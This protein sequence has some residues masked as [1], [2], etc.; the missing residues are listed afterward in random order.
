[1]FKIILDSDTKSFSTVSE[2]T[3]IFSSIPELR[4][5]Q[6]ILPKLKGAPSKVIAAALLVADYFR[7]LPSQGF[8]YGTGINP[9]G[10]Y[11]FIALITRGGFF[12]FGAAMP[13]A[14]RK[15]INA[16]S[17][18]NGNYVFDNF[19]TT[20]NFGEEDFIISYNWLTESDSN[21]D[22]VVKAL[23]KFIKDHQQY[24]EFFKIDPGE[25]REAKSELDKINKLDHELR[26]KESVRFRKD[27][28]EESQK[29]L[30]SMN[31]A[32]I[33]KYTPKTSEEV[34]RYRIKTLMRVCKLWVNKYRG[35]IDTDL[36][37]TMH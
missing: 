24:K 33:D 10:M 29:L 9:K 25:V 12:D 2:S 11:P 14:L 37:V 18:G 31:Q 1:M 3:Q 16:S 17:Y 27:L 8:K 26:K 7:P 23:I 34:L 32:V 30:E 22:Q 21:I 13:Q 6:E 20:D 15:K 19:N 28:S 36:K 4:Q 35:F 5:V